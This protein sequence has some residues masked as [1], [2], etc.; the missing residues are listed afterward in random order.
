MLLTD[1]VGRLNAEIDTS[2]IA[3]QLAKVGEQIT[4]AAAAAS[5]AGCLILRRGFDV[6]QAERELRDYCGEFGVA[7]ARYYAMTTT[8]DIYRSIDRARESVLMLNVRAHEVRG[9]ARLFGTDT[10]FGE[11]EGPVVSM[12]EFAIIARQVCDAPWSGDGDLVA[13][14]GIGYAGEDF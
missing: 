1:I 6:H 4:R 7:L 9:V 2:G 5:R 12:T 10:H 8:A 13:W 14:L 3:R 11:A